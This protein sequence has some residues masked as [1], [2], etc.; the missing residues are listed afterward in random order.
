MLDVVIFAADPTHL[1]GTTAL[2]ILASL[3]FDTESGEL[4]MLFGH[5]ELIH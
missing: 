1:T 4:C 5:V 3:R 2:G